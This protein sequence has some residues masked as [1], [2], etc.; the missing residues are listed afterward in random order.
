MP[1]LR[2]VAQIASATPAVPGSF[3]LRQSIVTGDVADAIYS[4]IPGSHP[5]LT[6]LAI[7]SGMWAFD[8]L[9]QGAIVAPLTVCIIT[10]IVQLYK[11]MTDEVEK[12]TEQ[13]ESDFEN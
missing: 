3:L 13:K 2:C 1:R 6:G 4:E 11:E 9:L 10:A 5:Y 12:E 7:F 8:D